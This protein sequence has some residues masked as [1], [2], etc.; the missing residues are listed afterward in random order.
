MFYLGI[1]AIIIFA[2]TVLLWMFLTYIPIVKA[3]SCPTKTIII[4]EDPEDP[5]SIFYPPIRKDVP[6]DYP[7]KDIGCESD[8]KPTSTPLPIAN[9]PISYYECVQ[10]LTPF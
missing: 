7:P 5:L 2:V 10:N 1:I 4:K 3:E 6:L 9:I 8:S